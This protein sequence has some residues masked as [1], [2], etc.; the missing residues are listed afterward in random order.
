VRN[1][2]ISIT[3]GE[4]YKEFLHTQVLEDGLQQEGKNGGE[5]STTKG[6]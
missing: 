1:E 6:R 3:L 2:K 4:E 5:N